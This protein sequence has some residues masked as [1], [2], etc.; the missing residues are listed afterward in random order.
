MGL[1]TV[2]LVLAVEEEFGIDIS[3]ADAVN[4]A[5]LGNLNDYVVGAVRQRGDTPDEE[6]IR[7]RL[8]AVVVAQLVVPPDAVTRQAHVVEDLGAE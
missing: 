3:N 8:S 5:V 2:E 1:D 6:Q 7:E 4:L